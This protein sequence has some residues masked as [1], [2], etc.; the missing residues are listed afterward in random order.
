MGLWLVQSGP[1]ELDD[2]GA[3]WQA[4]CSLTGSGFSKTELGQFTLLT[5]G[6][7]CHLVVV[8]ETSGDWV[9]ALAADWFCCR[10]LLPCAL[11]TVAS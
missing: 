7:V 9:R 11:I 10:E 6:E 3:A 2:L 1:A 5:G 8:G 4:H